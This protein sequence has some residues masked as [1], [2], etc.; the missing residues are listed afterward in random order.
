MNLFDTEDEAGAT[1]AA[2]ALAKPTT[3]RHLEAYGYRREAVRKWTAERAETVLR[4]CRQE[5]RIAL[6]RA[7]KVAE[8][9]DAPTPRGQASHVE[10]AE[11]ATYVEQTLAKGCGVDDLLQALAYSLYVSTDDELKR[12]AGY[13]VK[14]WRGA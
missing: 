8:E 10:R 1:V 7:K 4:N 13:L 12:L 5:E 9:Q 11:A 3:V 2:P 6:N 14:L